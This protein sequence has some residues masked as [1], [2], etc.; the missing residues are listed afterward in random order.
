MHAS[1]YKGLRYF[2]YLIGK[3]L[4]TLS[5]NLLVYLRFENFQKINFFSFFFITN[6]IKVIENQGQGNLENIEKNNNTFF[7]KSECTMF[8][9]DMPEIGANKFKYY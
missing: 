8:N 1:Q 4:F 6:Y 9:I 7:H 3:G 2:H 5:N